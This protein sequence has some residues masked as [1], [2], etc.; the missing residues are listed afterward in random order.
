MKPFNGSVVFY[1]IL[2]LSIYLYD[3]QISTNNLD[4]NYYQL[5]THNFFYRVYSMLNGKDPFT[6]H[7]NDCV[8]D[9]RK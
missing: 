1:E 2:G 4:L 8:S 6:R 3:N 7:D 5:D 9:S